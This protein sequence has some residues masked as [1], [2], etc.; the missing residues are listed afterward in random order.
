MAD[1]LVVDD[2]AHIREALKDLLESEGYEVRTASDGVEALA[3]YADKRPDLMLLDVM[4]PRKSGYDVC[5]AIREKDQALP[6]MMLTAKAEEVDEVLG[7]ERG[8]TDY[9]TKPY[10]IQPLLARIAAHL[11]QV[12]AFA[13]PVEPEAVAP[14]F[15][16]GPFTVDA[17]RFVLISARGRETE[18]TRREVG[19]LRYFMERP[20]KVVQR[21]DLWEEFWSDDVATPRVVDMQVMGLRRKLGADGPKLIVTKHG[22]GYIYTGA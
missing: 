12:A 6:I 16:F 1:I 13:A 22:E 11:R 10:S 3:A 2:E 8:A 7:L 9:V 15:A 4:M 14:Q 19:I 17:E 5:R 21:N 20:K 18:L